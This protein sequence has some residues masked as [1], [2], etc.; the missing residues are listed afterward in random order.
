[1]NSVIKKGGIILSA[2]IGA[3]VIVVGLL[4]LIMPH[5]YSS[6]TRILVVQKYT[7]TDSYTATKS[8]EKI[9]R[10]LSSVLHT[11]TFIDRVAQTGQVNLSELLILPE[12]DKRKE[13]AQKVNAE[14]VSGTSMLEITA[15]DEDQKQAEAIVNTVA[16][17]L[18]TE[19]DAYHGAG[20]TVDLQVVDSALTSDHPT[21][22]NILLYGPAAFL[23]GGILGI[24]YLFF[25]PSFHFNARTLARR[26]SGP[27]DEDATTQLEQHS[28]DQQPVERKPQ[29]VSLP[30]S[31]SAPP[32]VPPQPQV[33]K[34]SPPPMPMEEPPKHQ[35]LHV[36]NFDMAQPNEQSTQQVPAQTAEVHTIHEHLGTRPPTPPA[37]QG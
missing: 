22:P 13:W 28:V 14:M 21:R 32:P 3:A 31:H 7:L 12:K 36:S 8:A 9:S 29:P 18:V 1:M 15:Y 2:A 6:T 11:S 30:I 23:L 4:W 5:E 24:L 27:V 17:V 35:V 16:N 19:G 26:G 34:M 25:Q 10:G 37:Q 20:D 33:E